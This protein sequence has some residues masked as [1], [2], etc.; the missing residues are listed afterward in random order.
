MTNPAIDS[1]REEVIMG[2][3][4]YIGPESESAH[5]DRR[6][7]PSASYPAS[8]R[9]Q[10]RAQVTQDNRRARLAQQAHRHHLATKSEGAEG[11]EAC[12]PPHPSRGGAAAVDE[13]YSLILLSPTALR[14]KTAYR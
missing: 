1:I 2:V 3:E 11:L 14:A 12:A 7:R 8:D 10:R 6:A 4:C 9:D 13:G 5:D